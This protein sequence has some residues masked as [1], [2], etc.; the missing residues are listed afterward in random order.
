MFVRQDSGFW[1][2]Y[3]LIL[4]SE[5]GVTQGEIGDMV[6]RNRGHGSEDPGQKVRL[7]LLWDGDN[8]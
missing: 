1:R 2:V 7:T 5:I 4:Q 6:E 8:V 3:I